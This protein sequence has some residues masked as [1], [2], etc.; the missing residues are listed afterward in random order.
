[1]II[2]MNNKTTDKNSS[3]QWKETDDILADPNLVKE[4]K[5]AEN[6]MEKGKGIP[7]EKVKKA[8]TNKV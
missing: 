3:C 1:M 4:I 8:L 6:E 2:V 5:L 7:W